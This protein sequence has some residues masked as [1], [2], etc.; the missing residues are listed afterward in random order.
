MTT[1]AWANDHCTSPEQSKDVGP[2]EPQTYGMPSRLSAAS[3]M[4]RST[5]EETRPPVTGT[6]EPAGALPVVGELPVA[7]VR[8]TWTTSCSTWAACGM[9][10]LIL[11][12]S[13]VNLALD[14][15]LITSALPTGNP[16]D[17]ATRSVMTASTPPM[18]TVPKRPTRIF[19]SW[20]PATVTAVRSEEHTSELQ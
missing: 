9:S 13:V 12:V 7:G 19:V 10:F 16:S 14:A 8:G 5:G 3:S 11:W 2:F 18:P 17:R 20:R 15:A 4:V 1:P 6:T